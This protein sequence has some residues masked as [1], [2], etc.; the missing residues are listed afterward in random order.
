M[1]LRSSRSPT[2]HLSGI[3]TRPVRTCVYIHS[4]HVARASTV[5][6]SRRESG[7]A[8]APITFARGGKT[9]AH[10]ARTRLSDNATCARMRDRQRHTPLVLRTTDCHGPS[11]VFLADFQFIFTCVGICIGLCT[12]IGT[13]CW[14]YAYAQM[15]PDIITLRPPV[16]SKVK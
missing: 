13:L 10:G 3:H 7:G 4:Q 8:H 9:S 14:R 6:A 15:V 11:E 2:R 16:I 1:G 5:S 12:T